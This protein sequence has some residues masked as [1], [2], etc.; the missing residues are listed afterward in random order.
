MVR[1]QDPRSGSRSWVWQMVKIQD[2]RSQSWAS[3]GCGA[4]IQD[5][6]S[7]SLLLGVVDG[8]PIQDPR[9]QS[10]ASRGCSGGS[11]GS[12][13]HDPNPGAPHTLVAQLKSSKG[14]TKSKIHDPNPGA[15]HTLV[16]QRKSSKGPMVHN[17]RSASWGPGAALGLGLLGAA[18]GPQGDNPGSGLQNPDPLLYWLTTKKNG[19]S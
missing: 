11:P 13:I 1:I 12:K 4:K 7:G 16:A 14:P 5:P 6:R 19:I 10:W 15:L 8:H 17:P 2:P 18:G 3:R 9:S